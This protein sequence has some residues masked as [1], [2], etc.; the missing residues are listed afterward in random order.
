MDQS[1][2][3]RRRYLTEGNPVHRDAAR[4]YE[5]SNVRARSCAPGADAT[6]MPGGGEI[7]ED[8]VIEHSPLGTG[9]VSDADPDGGVCGHFIGSFQLDEA[10]MG[11]VGNPGLHSHGAASLSSSIERCA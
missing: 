7:D 5:S 4:T 1:G 2:E 3:R 10:T 9:A 6:G 8:N 11:R